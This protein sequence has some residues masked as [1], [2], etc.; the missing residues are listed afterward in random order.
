LALSSFSGPPRDGGDFASSSC[1]FICEEGNVLDKNVAIL[2]AMMNARIRSE[3]ATKER[4][5]RHGMKLCHVFSL[6]DGIEAS[7][8]RS[9]VV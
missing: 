2:C 5:K 6:F 9:R 8:T 7:K 1:A 3:N 4:E